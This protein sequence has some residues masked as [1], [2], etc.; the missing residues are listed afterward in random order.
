MILES[1]EL[2]TSPTSPQPHGI[3]KIEDYWLTGVTLHL[4]YARCNLPC[5][6]FRFYGV[7][8]FKQRLLHY[9]SG[10]HNRYLTVSFAAWL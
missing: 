4:L 9:S 6:I 7:T 2:L 1:A 3:N 10:N 8:F 5:L